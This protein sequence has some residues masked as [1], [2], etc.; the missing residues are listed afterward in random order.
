[1][2]DVS[3]V[4]F[5]ALG[6]RP[7]SPLVDP[8]D[9]IAALPAGDHVLVAWPPGILGGMRALQVARALSLR[10]DLALVEV[11]MTV[12]GA[13]AVWVG[14]AARWPLLPPAAVAGLVAH[15][16]AASRTVSV[17]SSV[18]TLA[19][20]T[21]SRLHQ[22]GS[23]LPGT[24]YTTDVVGDR[25]RGVVRRGGHPAWPGPGQAGPVLAACSS[26]SSAIAARLVSLVEWAGGHGWPVLPPP[27]WSPSRRWAEVTVLSAEPAVLVAQWAQ[28][29]RI[30]ECAGCGREVVDR[31]CLFC[32]SSVEP[33]RPAA[34][35]RVVS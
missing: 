21:P 6:H 27:G 3:L 23:L 20:P 12:T 7:A 31:P 10:D 28:L 8:L 17:L 4:G 9:V 15:I 30:R 13:A 29:L 2:L 14:V 16:A 26:G 18:A 33:L 22:A 24:W 19:W 25:S 1:M 34:Q 35:S 32:G 11:D 5:P